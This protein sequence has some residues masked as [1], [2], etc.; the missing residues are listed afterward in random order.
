MLTEIQD[1]DA[2]FST[3]IELNS[4][5][6]REAYIQSA[7]GNDAEL[8]RQ[9]EE[10]VAAHF[11]AKSMSNKSA[12]AVDETLLPN[13]DSQ[14]DSE[15]HADGTEG[16]GTRIGVY[17]LVKQLGESRTSAVFLAEQKEPMRRQVAL[18]IIKGGHDERQAIARLEAE[19]QVLTQLKHPHIVELFDSGTTPYTGRPYLVMELVKGTPIT[20]YCDEHRLSPRQRLELFVSVCQAVQFVHQKG[21]IHYNI[22]PSNV[23]V[24]SS[25]G[26]PVPKV[27]DFGAAGEARRSAIDSM[28]APNMGDLADTLEYLSPEQADIKTQDVDSRSDV[29]S[30]GTLL[31]ELLTG[32][33]PVEREDRKSVV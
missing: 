5:Q 9:V 12:D 32:T 25:T 17:K 7:C 15:S 30:L 8:R 4:A 18:K 11:Q 2:I 13:R 21:V 14:R 10:R 20:V 22:K 29:Y 28:P 1:G 33:T 16:P 27:L 26:K 24:D 31:Y 6:E 19:R 3:A 23:L